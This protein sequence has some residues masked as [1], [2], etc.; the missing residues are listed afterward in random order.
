MSMLKSKKTNK[1]FYKKWLYKISLRVEG[2]HVFRA[3]SPSQ[4]RDIYDGRYTGNVWIGSTLK[5]TMLRNKDLILKLVD[6]LKDKDPAAWSKR[7]ERNCLDLYTNDAVMFNELSASFSKETI[8]RFEP[9][10][11][12]IADLENSRN[13]ICKK[14]PHNRYRYRVY[15]RPHVI[16]YNQEVKQQFIDWVKSQCPRITWSAD[17]EDWFRRINYNWDRRYI[18]V[19]DEQT[20]LMLKLK[21]SEVLGTIYNFVVIDK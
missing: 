18:L 14:L 2:A 3:F 10:E 15:L 4:L 16:A 8:H 1:K 6:F 20:L 21:N 9:L 19:E 13:I 7:V 5:E 12:T 11:G 17:L